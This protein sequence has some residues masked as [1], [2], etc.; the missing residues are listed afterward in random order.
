MDEKTS[1]SWQYLLIPAVFMGFLVLY[2]QI[3]LWVSKGSLWNGSYVVSNYDETAYSAY[4]NSLADGKPRT[5]DPFIAVDDTGHESLYSVQFIPAYLI[6]LPTRWFG[7]STS[8]AFILLGVLSA[9][10]SSLVLSWF[11]FSFTEQPLL[12]SAGALIVLCFGT[13]AALQGELARMVSGNVLIDF[14]PFV[15]RYQPGLAFPLFFVFSWLFWKSL[16]VDDKKRAVAYSVLAG[17]ILA[18]LV[19]SYFYLWTAAAAWALCAGVAAL[20]FRKDAQG[21]TILSSVVVGSIAGPSLI[22]YWLMLSNRAPELDRVQLLESTHSPVL[23]APPLILGLLGLLVIGIGSVRGK[24]GVRK[25][26]VLLAM[27]LF[28]TPIVLFNQQVVTGRS[29]Q[30]V[31]YE[32]FIANYLV[33]VAFVLLVS[34]WAR[35]SSAL[36]K[37]LLTYAAVGAVVW[38]FIEAAGSAS[39]NATASEIRDG[40]VPAVA[41]IEEMRSRDDAAPQR[42]VVLATNFI[43]SDI[44]PTLSTFRPLWNAHTSS[45]GG[46]SPE[47]NKR[48]F[49]HFLY[50]SGYSGKDLAEALNA[51]S[52]ETTA[53]IFGSNRA[54]P[55]LGS[56]QAIKPA[57]IRDE[58]QKFEAFTQNF[59]AKDAEDPRID[60]LIV[61]EKGE[62]NFTNIDKW[63]QRDAGH[64]TD[65]FTVF[66]LTPKN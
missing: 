39:F 63:Y 32:V 25:H 48:L 14:F 64:P 12:S 55:E 24:L 35:E 2:P 23:F 28:A 8:T 21:R 52:F 9:V 59:S 42:P 43:T 58:V 37:K 54:L 30:P 19:F 22:P 16:S 46:V 45:A 62:A 56:A 36:A 7:L 17:L 49:Y 31:H 41:A 53:A 18:V 33:L 29:L 57:E 6:A 60:Y 47:E 11:L 66:R 38:G 50:F 34:E 51:H 4:I 65:L 10:L 5:N 20:F 15:R 61:P 40:S 27:S 26:K 13:A 1:L 3:S 44:I